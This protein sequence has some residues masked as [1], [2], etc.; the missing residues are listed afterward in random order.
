MKRIK[1]DREAVDSLVRSNAKFDMDLFQAVGNPNQN[2]IMSSFSVSSTLGMLLNGAGGIT[3][4]QLRHG[5]GLTDD[6][7]Y[8]VFKDD[9]KNVL[10]LMQG[11]DY[12]TLNVANR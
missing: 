4:K 8:A 1:L 12:F 5:L 2:L 6:K 10:N 11:N 3:A 9:Y 7:D